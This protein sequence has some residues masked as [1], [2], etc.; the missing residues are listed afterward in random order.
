[1]ESQMLAQMSIQVEAIHQLLADSRLRLDI[2]L[3]KMISRK[4]GMYR[5]K[6]HPC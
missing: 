2:V 1:M 5:L 4:Y 6:K 3:F